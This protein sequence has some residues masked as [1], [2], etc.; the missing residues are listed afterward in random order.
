MSSQ[1][2][3]IALGGTRWRRF[4]AAFG[5]SFAAIGTVMVLM[6]T[7]VLALP[8]SISG[9]QFKVTASSLVAKD[10]ANGPA[11]IQYGNVDFTDPGAHK[12]ATGVAVTNLP[13]GGVLTNMHQTV[14]GP[15]GLGPIN[16]NWAYLVVELSA[17][18]ADASGGLVVD[19][20]SLNAHD[21]T[22]GNIQIGVQGPGGTFAQTADSVTINSIDQTAV[23]TSAGTFKLSDLGLSAH[24]EATCTP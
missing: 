3:A 4:A 5:T 9:T 18:K 12:G 13:A 24:L 10:N 14:C 16:S 23:Y 15:T 20:T 7:G 2:T 22:F 17:S 21:A 11:F 6:A 8:V 19:A 1:V